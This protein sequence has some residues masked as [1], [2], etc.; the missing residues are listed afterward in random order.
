MRGDS[1]AVAHD[2]RL[3]YLPARAQIPVDDLVEW[4]IEP[5]C[6]VRAIG[7]ERTMRPNPAVS[8]DLIIYSTF[9]PGQVTALDRSNG[10]FRWKTHIGTHGNESVLVACDRVLCGHSGSL[11]AL[12]RLTGKPIWTFQPADSWMYAMPSTDFKSVFIGD[13]DGFLH[14]IDLQTGELRWSASVT[15][16]RVNTTALTIGG[17]VVVASCAESRPS[18]VGLDSRTGEELWRTPI[19]GRGSSDQ[20]QQFGAFAILHTAQTIYCIEPETGIV[21][22]R[23]TWPRREVIK[24]V[25]VRDLLYVLLS[26]EY[27]QSDAPGGVKTGMRPKEYLGIQGNSIIY[28]LPCGRYTMS[29]RWDSGTGNLYEINDSGLGILDPFTGERLVQIS[30][31]AWNDVP[32]HGPHTFRL[33]DVAD[34]MM[35]IMV[36]DGRISA[37][38]HPPLSNHDA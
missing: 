26:P 29:V 23:W 24:I 31:D 9:R 10:A 36:D 6:E 8:G 27:L 35:Y 2:D 25:V 15:A 22:R 7:P 3:F 20:I 5:Q 21:A 1:N 14:S 16:G 32:N 34:G 38:R 11:I 30:L 12:E 28:R 13:T 19:A 18:A 17:I 4:V 33:P 37:L